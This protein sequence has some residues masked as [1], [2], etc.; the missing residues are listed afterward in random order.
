MKVMNAH[1]VLLVTLLA[2]FTLVR[3]WGPSGA[4]EG[5]GGRVD[6]K[7]RSAKSNLNMVSVGGGVGGGSMGGGDKKSRVLI[8]PD[9]DSDEM[10]IIENF[11]QI[12][13]GE[14]KRIGII[15]TQDL[16]D[17]H[18]Q[19][20]ELLTYALVLSGNHIYTSGSA[21]NIEN[22]LKTTNTAVIYGALRACSSEL[23]TVILP[24][25]LPRQP[26]EMQ[27]LLM[28]VANLIEHPENDDL[29]FKDA[30]SICND[31]V[32]SCVDKL[33]IFAYHDS[34]YVLQCA[35]KV[36]GKM[37]ITKFFLD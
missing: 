28:R 13:Q 17:A 1:E 7:M 20:I 4:R 12:Q 18:S 9:T 6:F 23:L 34:K 8:A 11:G 14:R 5:F 21:G 15:G 29:E 2:L 10:M 22:S 26:A 32:L 35:D 19:M 25:S 31:N 16:S 37:E 3:G 24:Q 36:Q 33:L 30:V 27:T